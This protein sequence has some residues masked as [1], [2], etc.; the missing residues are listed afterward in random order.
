MVIKAPR[1]SFHPCTHT[2]TP[3]SSKLD[4]DSICVL[5]PYTAE[6]R[7]VQP[8]IS[9]LEA[10]YGHS[11]IINPYQ[12][13]YQ[14]IHPCMAGS[15]DSVKINT[16]LLMM[17]EWIIYQSFFLDQVDDGCTLLLK[18]ITRMRSNTWPKKIPDQ[19]D[20]GWLWQRWRP[21]LLTLHHLWHPGTE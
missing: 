20:D 8:N 5:Y 18:F 16:S 4:G 19:V 10:V 7:D 1:A 15:I 13:M 14:E 17:R 9:R 3:S 21:H 11:L 6:R 2:Q 12:G